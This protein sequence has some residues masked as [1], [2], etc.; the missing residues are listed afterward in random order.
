GFLQQTPEPASLAIIGLG[1][2]LALGRRR[3]SSIL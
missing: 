2:L 3:P 1:S